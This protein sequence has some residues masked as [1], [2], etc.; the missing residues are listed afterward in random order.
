[1]GRV[2][3]DALSGRADERAARL[4][5]ARQ[6]RLE[7]EKGRAE[8]DARID[9]AVADVYLAQEERARALAAVDRADTKIGAAITLVLAEGV[10]IAQVADLT[11]LRVKQVQK[12]KAGPVEAMTVASTKTAPI[13]A[14][15]PGSAGVGL[16]GQPST[17]SGEHPAVR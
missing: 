1:M 10:P 17:A 9:Q 13:G 8:R 11:E 7:L 4:A 6:R 3:R 12:L 16:D 14:P 2:A 5:R 15:G